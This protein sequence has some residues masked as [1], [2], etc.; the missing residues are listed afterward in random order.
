MWPASK[1]DWIQQAPHFQ[2]RRD[3]F[4]FPACPPYVRDG[5]KK[6]GERGDGSASVTLDRLAISLYTVAKQVYKEVR[7]GFLELINNW[8]PGRRFCFGFVWDKWVL[9]L[10]KHIACRGAKTFVMYPLHDR[11]HR[12]NMKMHVFWTRPIDMDA[13]KTWSS[14]RFLIN[15]QMIFQFDVLSGEE[16]IRQ[17]LMMSLT[18]L[19]L[20]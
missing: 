1:R 13:S 12:N 20:P 18:R 11:L 15:E 16:G 5:A 14:N 7:R 4:S 2:S 8:K 10:S 3:G 17:I 19:N 9:F 6:S